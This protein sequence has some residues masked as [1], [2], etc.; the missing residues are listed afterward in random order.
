MV[1][2]KYMPFNLQ[3]ALG[4]AQFQRIDELVGKKVWI[5]N[6]YRRR[7]AHIQ[8]LLLNPD[9]IGGV[10][11]AWCTTAV[12]GESYAVTKEMAMKAMEAAHIPARPFFFPLSL[13]PAYPGREENSRRDNPVS[14]SV[15]A[16]GIC[17]PSAMNM[18]EEKIDMVC[19]VIES[20]VRTP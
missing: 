15:S 3:A 8:N 14:H 7:L 20:L 18:T 2:F 19:N 1:A 17:L 16:R 13:L 5:L 4:H 11:G 6:Q 12:F 9:P 10:N